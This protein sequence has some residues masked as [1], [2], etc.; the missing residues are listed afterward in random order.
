MIADIIKEMNCGYCGCI[1]PRQYA[2]N[3]RECGAPRKN[4]VRDLPLRVVTKGTKP[5]ALNYA[6]M[7]YD[8]LTRCLVKIF[9]Y[10]REVN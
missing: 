4:I 3:C 2:P 5:P 6:P 7:N 10:E 1:L 8:F 9:G